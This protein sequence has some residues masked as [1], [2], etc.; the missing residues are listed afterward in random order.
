LFP[1]PVELLMFLESFENNNRLHPKVDGSA[2]V[3]RVDCGE[4]VE[5]VAEEDS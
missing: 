4:Q 2:S 1:K 3:V 5:D